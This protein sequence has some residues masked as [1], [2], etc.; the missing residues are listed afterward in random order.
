MFLIL[1]FVMLSLVA[2][3]VFLY[4]FAPHSEMMH[5]FKT[6]KSF[7]IAQVI[8][9][10]FAAYLIGAH[11]N[12]LHEDNWRTSGI[13][14]ITL[15]AE[16]VI[17]TGSKSSVGLV[18]EKKPKAG[19]A[20]DSN[21]ITWTAYD[22]VT[23]EATKKWGGVDPIEKELGSKTNDQ[24]PYTYPISITFPKDGTWKLKVFSDG[25]PIKTIIIDV[26]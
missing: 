17:Y 18:L 24:V 11:F 14:P 20:F 12:G 22:D 1:G 19:E 15:N 13:Y 26:K 7:V 23:V 6:T 5:A 10:S 25:T 3:F 2:L 21:I 16:P 8:L 4:F 9:V